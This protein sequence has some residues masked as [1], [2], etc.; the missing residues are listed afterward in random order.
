MP[1]LL[2]QRTHISVIFHD[3]SV[4]HS[5]EKGILIIFQNTSTQI[6]NHFFLFDQV[7]LLCNLLYA[8][9]DAQ[10]IVYNSL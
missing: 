4:Y 7:M 6:E 5:K 2:L 9:S 8:L 3:L 10:I 1:A